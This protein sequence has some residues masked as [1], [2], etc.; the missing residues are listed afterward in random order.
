MVTAMKTIM[1]YIKAMTVVSA[2]ILLSGCS[3]EYEMISGNTDTFTALTEVSETKTLLGNGGYET[4][5]H[6]VYWTPRDAIGITVGSA[7]FTKYVYN[8][9]ENTGSADFEGEKIKGDVYSAVYPYS[10]STVFTD[11]RILLDLPEIQS[12]VPL[13]FD[14]LAF[15]MVARSDTRTLAFRNLCGLLKIDLRGDAEITS[16]TFTAEDVSGVPVAV[17]GRAE[18][19]MAYETAPQLYMSSGSYTSVTLDCG[20]GVVLDNTGYTPF[21]ISL[22]PGVY[23]NF[24]VV[25]YT[26]DG[27][28]MT[29]NGRR[30]VINRSMVR[31]VSDLEFAADPKDYDERK[32]LVEFYNATDGPN[33]VNNTNWC[34]DAPLST[35]YGLTTDEEGRVTSIVMKNN[36][37][38]GNAGSTLAP[39]RKLATLEV[40]NDMT[41]SGINRLTSLDVSRNTELKQLY[42]TNNSL[43][44]LNVSGNTEL[45]L[46]WC[47]NNRLTSLDLSGNPALVSLVCSSNSLNRLTLTSNHALEVLNC[48]DNALTSLNLSGNTLLGDLDC[49]NNGLR[50]LDISSNT[51]LRRLDCSDNILTS[52]NVSRN[53]ALQDI[54]C[55]DNDLTSLNVSGNTAITRLDC[56]SNSLR[57]LNVSRNQ[58]LTELSCY[59]NYLSSLDISSNTML[60]NNVYVG[61]QRSS[62]GQYS[63]MTLYLTGS[64][65]SRWNAAWSGDWR[66]EYVDVT[67]R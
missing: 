37:L 56:S 9:T 25:M 3:K 2:V 64:Q 10:A 4:L 16:I 67:V 53:A 5:P 11:N 6:K 42:C 58:G 18:V 54:N 47:G 13:S 35:W 49:S 24:K 62:D 15:P 38:S 1:G 7:A 57:S 55:A 21:Y 19:D 8:G 60:G 26:A 22:P 39:L 48:S 50:S 23:E 65:L 34:T 41:Q 51:A 63:R 43:Y 44:S 12:Y 45:T 61:R 20:E 28:K 30:L 46:L 52:L 36:G 17:A 31:P 40:D 66:N 14:P 33:W 59:Y 29:K 27:R 32:A